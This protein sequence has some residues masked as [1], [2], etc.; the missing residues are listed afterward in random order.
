VVALR[1][2][3]GY[4]G[5]MIGGIV[6]LSLAIFLFIKHHGVHGINYSAC[7]GLA[8]SLIAIF[9]NWL[10]ARASSG[11]GRNG[12]YRGRILC[13]P[14]T[15][16]SRSSLP[17][18]GSVRRSIALVALSYVHARRVRVPERQGDGAIAR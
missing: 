18:A 4:F 17:L 16:L 5:A 10:Q 11:S 6:A 15:S 12:T 7:S 2:R 14:R 1:S 8:F 3:I 13:K 9:S